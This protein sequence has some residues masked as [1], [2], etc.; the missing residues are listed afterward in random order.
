M[1]TPNNSNSPMDDEQQQQPKSLMEVLFGTKLKDSDIS[2]R[3]IERALDY[4]VEQE[5]TKQQYYRLE[6]IN[7]SI[8]LFKLARDLGVPSQEI[9]RLF[10]AESSHV[11]AVPAVAKSGAGTNPTPSAPPLSRN[12]TKNGRSSS[13]ESGSGGADSLSRQPL[14]YRFPPAGSNLLPRPVSLTNSS[15]ELSSWRTNSP[16][17]IGASA[18]AALNDSI[19]IKEE[20]NHTAESPFSRKSTYHNRNL[21]LP[22]TKLYNATI[23]SGMTS[24]LSFNKEDAENSSTQSTIP[25]TASTSN[26]QALTFSSSHTTTTSNNKSHAPSNGNTNATTLRKPSGVAKKHRRT[27]SA[28]SFGVID[29]N[30]I[31]EAKQ[32]DMQGRSSHEKHHEYDEKTCSESSSRNESPVRKASDSTDIKALN[33]VAKL[34]NNS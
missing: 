1:N 23:P 2:E 7:R 32:R 31:D 19:V 13:L 5:R 11:P 24:I 33:P 20:D 18:V 28:S 8:E 14:S 15:R 4:K 26:P 30:V 3:A 17:R 16:A 25:T 21:S 27:R 10:S 22:I 29:L 6:N 12:A 9:S 34:L